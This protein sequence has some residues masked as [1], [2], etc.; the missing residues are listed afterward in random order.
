MEYIHTKTIKSSSATIRVF[1]PVLT[2]E[3]RAKRM[4]AIHNAAAALLKEK[5]KNRGV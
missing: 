2:E 3:E 1:S 4:K 5:I